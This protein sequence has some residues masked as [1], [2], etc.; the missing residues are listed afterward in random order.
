MD[1][2]AIKA[3]ALRIYHKEQNGLSA[4]R[5]IRESTGLG[6]M[7]IKPLW[8]KWRE[9]GISSQKVITWH[10]VSELPE[11]DLEEPEYS[12]FLLFRENNRVLEG[13]YNLDANQII[14]RYD[15][16]DFRPTHWAYIDFLPE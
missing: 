2:E 8:E 16:P 10:P 4:I 14:Y 3:E 12:K 6:L 9:D 15:S 5:Y 11:K 7:E 1:I 13:Y